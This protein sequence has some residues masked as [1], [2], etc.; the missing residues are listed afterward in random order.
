MEGTP[1]SPPGCPKGDNAVAAQNDNC[2]Q[3]LSGPSQDR[4]AQHEGTPVS[5]AYKTITIEPS[6]PTKP[7][8]GAPCNGCGICCLDQPCPIGMVLTGRRH[9]ACL[10]LQW[11]S[12]QAQYRCGAIAQPARVLTERLPVRLRRLASPLAPLLAGL[13]R[14]SIALDAGCDC[15]LEVM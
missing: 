1:V 7:P 4:S 8:L 3:R 9:G 5:R 10:A 14:R 11:D 2:A 12:Q 13:A 6:A 15:D